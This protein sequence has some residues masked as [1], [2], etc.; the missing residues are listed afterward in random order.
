MA[1]IKICGLKIKED[2]ECVNLAKPD[3]AG[4]VFA[5]T[6]R[7]I[8]FKTAAKLR[9]LLNKDIKSVGVFVNEFMANIVSLCKDAAV[10]LVQLHGDE[11]E[12]YIG[13]LRQKIDNKIIKAVR[14]VDSLNFKLPLNAD[15]VLF[16]SDAGSGKTFDW[17]LIPK[18]DKPFFLA[19]GLNKDNMEEA[20]KLKPYCVDLSSGVE[21]GGQKDF[22]KITEI[23][24]MARR[25]Q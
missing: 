21:T 1:K 10:D 6:K 24:K 17:K 18:T 5:G 3:Y 14:V 13:A 2:V 15:F 8:D 12:N 25:A 9:S 20:L 22:D 7:K 19:G 23:V 11:D 16:D 4:F